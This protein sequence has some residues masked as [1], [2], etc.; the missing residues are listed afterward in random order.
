M[1]EGNVSIYFDF[2]G[3]LCGWDECLHVKHVAL[4]QGPQGTASL[5]AGSFSPINMEPLNRS[6]N[7]TCHWMTFIRA[8]KCQ[9]A[10]SNILTKLT[11]KEVII[12]LDDFSLY[13]VFQ[14]PFIFLCE[15]LNPVHGAYS[16]YMRDPVSHHR[17]LPSP[18]YAIASHTEEAKFWCDGCCSWFLWREIVLMIIHFSLVWNQVGSRGEAPLPKARSLKWD[19]KQGF[20]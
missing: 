5:L 7:K 18:L 16:R 13:L 12:S 17:T 8:W 2:V 11:T 14:P 15:G 19:V 1:N 9:Q 20:M 6:G 3:C 4:G 10:K